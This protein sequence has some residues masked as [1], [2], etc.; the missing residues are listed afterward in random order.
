M[1]GEGR[2]KAVEFDVGSRD[3]GFWEGLVM[4]RKG[5]GV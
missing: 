5:F 1:G 4:K 3:L 2:W